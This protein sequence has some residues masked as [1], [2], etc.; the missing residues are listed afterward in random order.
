MNLAIALIAAVAFAVLFREPMRRHPVV[1]YALAIFVDVAF[2]TRAISSLSA[3]AGRALFPYMQQGLFAFGLLSVVM[4][5]GVLPEKS[6]VKR[7]LRPVRGELSVVACI[8]IVGHVLNYFQPV[9]ARAL[10]GADVRASVFAGVL[11]S[12]ALVALLLILMATSFRRVRDMMRATSWKRIQLLAYPFYLLVFCHVMAMLLPS[13][14]SGAGRAITAV[15]LYAVLGLS[16]V[17]LRLRR[18]RCEQG[19]TAASPCA[20]DMRCDGAAGA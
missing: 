11:I 10:G 7:Y 2:L 6:R 4:F 9:F 8:L 19:G 14:L 3:V 20:A 15:A 18:M 1:F 5:L 17:S 16:Y 12:V 13:A